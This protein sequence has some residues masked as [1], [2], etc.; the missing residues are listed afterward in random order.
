[1]SNLKFPADKLVLIGTCRDKLSQ[2]IKSLGVIKLFLGVIS[3][4]LTIL[5]ICIFYDRLFNSITEK[6]TYSSY[7]I[8]IGV[9][10]IICMIGLILPIY[11]KGLISISKLLE[12]IETI[13]KGKDVSDKKQ[14]GEGF[15]DESLDQIVIDLD[16]D[17]RPEHLTINFDNG[18]TDKTAK[19]PYILQF[20]VNSIKYS[21][22]FNIYYIKDH[23]FAANKIYIFYKANNIIRTDHEKIIARCNTPK[24]EQPIVSLVKGQYVVLYSSLA[25]HLNDYVHDLK[26]QIEEKVYINKIVTERIVVYD[27]DLESYNQ[28]SVNKQEEDT[29]E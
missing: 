3:L 14:S 2:S 22:P 23:Y 8:G 21:L 7:V 18:I 9:C 10:I 16:S 17:E 6:T 28:A 4:L 5:A 13:A 11:K 27:T 25:K 20:K 26:K 29:K 12:E 15:V 24:E 1:M 19:F